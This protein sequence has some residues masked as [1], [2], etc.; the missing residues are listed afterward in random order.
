MTKSGK[1][2]IEFSNSDFS[3][4]LDCSAV[5]HSLYSLNSIVYFLKFFFLKKLFGDKYLDCSS[6]K[7]CFQSNTIEF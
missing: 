7:Q 5:F 2:S 3:L 1:F 6:H 4:V